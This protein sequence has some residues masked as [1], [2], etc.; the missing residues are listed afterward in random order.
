MMS[1]RS[2]APQINCTPELTSIVANASFL[3]ERL[4]SARFTADNQHNSEPEIDRRLQHWCQV[5]A[6]D[7]WDTLQKRL[8]WE[9]L[10]LDTVRPLLGT[11]RLTTTESLP[12]WAETLQQIIQTATDFTSASAS[13]LP[14]EA[15]NPIVF[16][17]VL[18]PAIV[19]A[20]QQLLTRLGSRQ[21][22]ADSLPLS[23][24][25]ADAY[26]A[27][28]RSLLQR[29][30][31]LC[32]KTLDFE[33]SQVRPVGESL[34]NLLGLE[35]EISNSKTHY[36]QF[37]DRLL[38]D[39]LL[40]LFQKYPV[41]GRL[42]ATAVN[43]WVEFA[44]EF[45][46]RL[47][48]DGKDIHRVFGTTT[49]RS[50]Q[51]KVTDIQTSL[52]D[53]HQRGRTVILLTFESGLKLVYK[54]KDL[55]LEVA[56]NQLLHWC[57]QHR[58]L[59]DF[60]IIQV[61]NRSGYGWV[62]CVEYQSC[63]DGAAAERFY[64][65]AGMLLCLLYTL[66]ANDCHDENLIA[67]GEYLVPIDL[68]TLMHHEANPIENSPFSQ[69]FETTASQ[70]F[71]DSVL[72]T[73]LLP[74]WDFSSDRRIAYDIS[75]LGSGNDRQIS[76]KVPRWQSINTDNM[77][78]RYEVVTLPL[79]QNVPRL[80]EIVLS[81]NDYQSQIVAGF[82]RMYRF[83]MANKDELLVPDSPLAAMQDL[84]IRFIFRATQIYGTILQDTWVPDRLKHGVDYSIELDRLCCAF[85][86]AQD[87]PP[88]WS[89]LSAE[90]QAMEQLDIPVFAAT[91]SSDELTVSGHPSI[92]HY[93]KQP[94]YQQVLNQ[95]QALDETDLSRQIAIIQGSFCAK[96]AQTS[97]H[98]RDRWDA[99]SLPLLNSTQLIEA[100]REIASEIAIKAIPDP[101]DSV[102]WIGLGY[103]LRAERFQLQ[104][105]ND[106]LYDGRCGVALFLAALSQVDGDPRLGKL[107]L[108]TLQSL[109]RQIHT[110]DLESQQ[111]TARLTG[112]GGAAGLGA[113]IYTFV[114]VSQFLGDETLLQDALALAAWISLESI[115]ADKYLDII[116]GAAGAMLGLLSLYEVT[117]ATTVL[118]KAM[119]CGEHLLAHQVSYK[120]APKAWQTSGEIPLT[121][122]SHG[123]AGISY[124]LLRLY[125]VTQERNYLE[126]AQA[127]IEYERN[128]FSASHANWPDFRELEH[129]GQPNFL[130]HWCHGAAGIGLGRLGC[131]NIANTP[132]IEHEIEI[133]LQTTQHYGLQ[134]IDHLCCGN[135][136]RVEVLLVGAQRCARADWH[137]VALQ[138][139]TNVVAKAKHTGAYQL[140]SNLP[141]SVFNPGFFRG[142]AGIGY[143]L[144]RLAQPEQLP[145]VLLWE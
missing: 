15:D 14:T 5:V 110:L 91:A 77:H 129:T 119:A 98:D 90:L 120:G 31:E 52:S 67:S 65:R 70:Q 81:A 30:S 55:G 49:V 88:A 29:L 79:E 109:R 132:A 142:T 39:G 33:F 46:H 44:A 10:N 75:G 73:G 102:N 82:D 143:Q 4:D 32:A 7:N 42:M 2:I 63:V 48:Q 107:A 18:L 104:V 74:R 58:Q 27:L 105:L 122:F 78:L 138:N 84:Q 36:T 43:F 94:S 118:D 13:F 61:L 40:T 100:A 45:L 24:L 56:F 1:Q 117:G 133:A 41:L 62:E 35:P 111:R 93:F 12:E 99:E 126:A 86:I 139:A 59:L 134:S 96:L 17:D 121:G 112:I 113:T 26:R 21:L 125:A 101:N 131:F 54:P 3:W 137:Q 128:V 136:G 53:P 97:S 141:N 38:Q 60:K 92:R 8:Q 25:S 19:V 51:N 23:M 11:V 123:A 37:V 95:L 76:R 85:L 144:L 106:S 140:F 89:I 108:Q 127:G 80:G 130:V 72:R 124:A 145:S 87:K 114:K 6:Q 47:A 64:Q 50:A 83:L 9:G 28:E 68:E 66:R 135:M 22:T 71:W 20:R 57:N 116:H 115:A 34:L 103:E 69:E 16:E